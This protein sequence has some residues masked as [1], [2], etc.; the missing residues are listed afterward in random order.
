MTNV[1]D[2][3]DAPNPYESLDQTNP[4]DNMDAQSTPE[5]TAPQPVAFG[6]LGRGGVEFKRGLRAGYYMLGGSTPEDFANGLAEDQANLANYPKTEEQQQLEAGLSTDGLGAL[7]QHPTAIPSMLAEGVPSMLGMLPLAFG[8][9][10]AG[11]AAGSA[12]PVVGNIAGGIAGGAIGTGIGAG[13]TEYG[14]SFVDYMASHG[15][16]I[17]NPQATLQALSSPDFV[18]AAHYY[19]ADR[20]G[21]SAA[22]NT[23]GAALGGKVAARF[24]TP[25]TKLLSVEGAKGISAMGA[26]SAGTQAATTA[27]QELSTDGSVNPNQVMVDAFLSGITNLVPMAVPGITERLVRGA[28]RV[29]TTHD[30]TDTVNAVDDTGRPVEGAPGTLP[31]ETVAPTTPFVDNSPF[32]MQDAAQVETMKTALKTAPDHAT[33]DEWNSIFTAAMPKDGTHPPVV[34]SASFATDAPVSKEEILRNLE[35][36]QIVVDE[37]EPITRTEQPPSQVGPPHPTMDRVLVLNKET[38]ATPP[39]DEANPSPVVRDTTSR[40]E[41]VARVDVSEHTDTQG[42]RVLVIENVDKPDVLPIQSDWGDVVV[43]RVGRWAAE[44]G[45]EAVS[46]PKEGGNEPPSVVPSAGAADVH[47]T[48]AESELPPVRKVANQRKAER[49]TVNVTKADGQKVRLDAV[50]SEAFADTSGPVYPKKQDKGVWSDVA[51]AVLRDPR[52]RDAAIAAQL[53]S[54]ALNELEPKFKLKKP[55][56]VMI[57]KGQ[58]TAYGD[59][60]ETPSHYRVRIHLEAHVNTAIGK[61]ANVAASIYT[62]LWHEFGH[63]LALDKWGSTDHST[64]QSFIEA[65]RA[66]IVKPLSDP[67]RTTGQS[68]F[69]RR[70]FVKALQLNLPESM[71]NPMNALHMSPQEFIYITSFSEWFAEQVAKWSITSPKPLT[72]LEK[73]FSALA[74]K[75][76]ELFSF[77]AKKFPNVAPEAHPDIQTWLDAFVGDIKAQFNVGFVAQQTKSAMINFRAML[78]GGTPHVPATPQTAATVFTR[79]MLQ[80]LMG[81]AGVTPGMAHGAALADK[82]NVFSKYMLSLPQIAK[83]NPSIPGL[84]LYNEG[85]RQMHSEIQRMR[86]RATTTT[87]LWFGLGKKNGISLN[88]LI[89][90]YSDMSYRSA[91]EVAAKVSRK[92]TQQEL[93]ALFAKHQAGKEV[94]ATFKQVTDDLEFMLHMHEANLVEQAQKITDPVASAL[95]IAQV[96]RDVQRMLSVPYFPWMRFG[97]FT[98]TI[99]DK[100]GKVAH[101]ETF[102]SERQRNQAAAAAENVYP[103]IAFDIL[104]GALPEDVR[105]LL[106]MPPG[107]LDRIHSELVLSPTQKKMLEELRF[108]LAPGASFKHRF[109]QKQ[110]TSGYSQDFVRSYANYMF[111][112]SSFIGRTKYIEPLETFIHSVRTQS[113]FMPDG[114]KRSQIASFMSQHLA[115]IIDAKSDFVKLKGMIF[116]FALGFNPAAAALNLSQQWLGTLPFLMAKFGDVKGMASLLKAQSSL[117]TYYREAT[118]EKLA[119][120]DFLFRALHEGMKNGVLTEAMAPWLAG[121]SEGRNLGRYLGRQTSERIWFDFSKYS[122]GFF[123][124][125]EQMN[126]RVTFRAALDLALRDPGSKHVQEVI[127]QNQMDYTRLR[128]EGW[129]HPEAAAYT[130]AQDAVRT[131]QFEYANYA[132]P[133]FM[134]GK[135]GAVFVFKSFVQNS[136]FMLWNYPSTMVRGIL[137]MGFLGGL[138]GLPGTED[139]SDVLKTMGYQFFGKDFDLEREARQFVNDMSS[140]AVDPSLLLHGI[141]REGYGL[142]AVADMLGEHVGLGDVPVPTFDR[143]GSIGLGN[144]LPVQTSQLFGPVSDPN[145][146]IAG[147]AQNASGALFS[148]AFNTYK[149]LVDPQLSATDMKRWERMMPTVLKNASRMYRIYN[150]GMERSASGAPV[151]TFDPND[152]EQMMEILGIGIGYQPLALTAAYDRQRAIS[153]VMAFWQLRHDALLQQLG[154][155]FNMGDKEEYHYILGAVK[156][157]NTDLPKEAKLFAV[158]S[159]SIKQSV[160]NR[161]KNFKILQRGGAIDKRSAGI[162]KV[163]D[164]LYPEVEVGT[165]RVH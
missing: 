132:R 29:R 88:G 43:Q 163:I 113:E 138:M 96:Q 31:E 45:F 91:A 25:E 35:S 112:G 75:L 105:P 64:Q 135:A 85:V 139:L 130:T 93:Q 8:G 144:I 83:R 80:K 109:Q 50:R 157:F 33:P 145:K 143:S 102:E 125:S 61:N 2:S 160:Q 87:K 121:V 131:T 70:N 24:F 12:V 48:Q 104:R 142:P 95:R 28:K 20:A 116:H 66:A 82:Y 41:P 62:T 150:E 67:K 10:A 107:L 15:V 77:Y 19:A 111:H 94:I 3:L 126:R 123:Q 153:E 63:A 119:P 4:Y 52:L 118:M 159:D 5:A 141:S 1:Y 18:N 47:I 6:S 13:A 46:W 137:I 17:A 97:D 21:I 58:S 49:I 60:L 14:N 148:V 55:L 164:P 149:A 122:A 92:P 108:E 147:A 71:P 9:A 81:S 7:L 165:R 151:Q 34:P 23:A 38:P 98:L 42:R 37:Q 124:M 53:A 127:Q 79:S 155:A 154:N 22:F 134:Q 39:M 117:S 69:A 27:G 146:A 110:R 128:G 103:K 140:G 86:D 161:S 44:N 76:K 68:E 57:V 106:G 36:R 56:Q 78:K 65:W 99:R 89:E 158:T 100:S 11:G 51:P 152:T 114:T 16:D 72:I 84:Q 59:F 54:K 26:V 120:G 129:T 101:F 40:L 90:D 30:V 162:I 73:F 115:Q 32:A 156:K 74:G 133:R 136:L